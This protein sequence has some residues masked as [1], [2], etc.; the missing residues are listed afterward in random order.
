MVLDTDIRKKQL[1][2]LKEQFIIFMFLKMGRCV[3]C[4]STW[5]FCAGL[6]L[7]SSVQGLASCKAGGEGLSIPARHL[8]V[9][10]CVCVHV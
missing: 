6:Q 5:Q 9:I 10:V 2:I 7:S 4:G 1:V 3:A 8:C